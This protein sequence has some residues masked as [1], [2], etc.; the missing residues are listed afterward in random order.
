MYPKFTSLGVLIFV[1]EVWE[2]NASLNTTKTHIIL[3]DPSHHEK[4]LDP[5]SGVLE[6]SNL[7]LINLFGDSL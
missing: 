6:G 4:F 7:T 1:G 3:L 5:L 2:H